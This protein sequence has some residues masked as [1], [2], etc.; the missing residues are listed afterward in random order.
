MQ[1]E[2]LCAEFFSSKNWIHYPLCELAYGWLV[3]SLRSLCDSF[4]TLGH[5]LGGSAYWICGERRRAH[6]KFAHLNYCLFEEKKKRVLLTRL[7]LQLHKLGTTS[8]ARGAEVHLIHYCG[9][10]VWCC[11]A[12]ILFFL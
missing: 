4:H 1:I 7:M 10:D 12:I 8:S 5:R 9:R 2:E 6:F 11:S 3:N